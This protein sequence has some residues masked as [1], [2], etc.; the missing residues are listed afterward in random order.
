MLIKL[1]S[2]NDFNLND[3]CDTLTF[4]LVAY[5]SKIIQNLEASSRMHGREELDA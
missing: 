4:G 1:L 2:F 3:D 5:E